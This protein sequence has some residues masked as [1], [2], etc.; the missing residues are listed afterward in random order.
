MS[1]LSSLSSEQEYLNKRLTDILEK[2]HLKKS[3]IDKKSI[4]EIE[5]ESRIGH[6]KI[7][8]SEGERKGHVLLLPYSSDQLKRDL[9]LFFE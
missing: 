1:L 5:E 3:A 8:L 9:N 6:Y 2:R 4:F 7:S